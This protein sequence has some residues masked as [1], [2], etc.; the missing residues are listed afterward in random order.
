VRDY[1]HGVAV[2]H[3]VFGRQERAAK[4]RPSAKQREVT[5]RHDLGP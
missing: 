5:R 4:R 2:E 3:L 1:R